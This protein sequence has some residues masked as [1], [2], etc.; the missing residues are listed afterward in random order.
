MAAM[1]CAPLALVELVD[2]SIPFVSI[3]RLKSA[4]PLVARLR[5]RSYGPEPDPPSF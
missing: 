2:R 1:G 5:G 4:L 3:E